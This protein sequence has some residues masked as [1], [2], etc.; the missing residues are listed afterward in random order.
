MGK[1]ITYELQDT[2]EVK[3]MRQV[4]RDIEKECK[5]L[6]GLF[7]WIK[8]ID[9]ERDKLQRPR[10]ARSSQRQPRMRQLAKRKRSSATRSKPKN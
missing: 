1:A 2:D 10:R 4:R 8:Q 7:E 9:R 5:T 6:A 3:R